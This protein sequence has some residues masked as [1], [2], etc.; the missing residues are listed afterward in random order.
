MVGRACRNVAFYR[1]AFAANQIDLGFSKAFMSD[2][3]AS[4]KPGSSAILVLVEQAWA[5]QTA[6]ELE[7]F[8]GH[9]LR[10][11]VKGEVV[12]K[13]REDSGG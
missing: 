5:D 10:H 13:L 12:E 8:T 11:A 1:S 4:L 3:R 6:A 9:L 7:K 2:L